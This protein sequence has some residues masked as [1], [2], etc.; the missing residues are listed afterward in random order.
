MWISFAF[1]PSLIAACIS[2][3]L[4]YLVVR[5]NI[6]KPGN[7]SAFVMFMGMMI[8]S[9]GE[10]IERLAG[11]PP[12]NLQYR[13]YGHLSLF[14]GPHDANLAYIGAII[15]TVGM[16]L[17]PAGI[18]HFTLDY[19]FKIKMKLVLRKII[20]YAVYLFSFGAIAIALLNDK[21]HY[22][23]IS[24]VNPYN[25]YGTIIW[26]LQPGRIHD[27]LS[28]W[29]FITGLT[30]MVVLF[31]KYR[32][33]K[34]NII[35]RQ[36]EITLIGFFVMFTIMVVTGFVPMIILNLKN[37]YPLM[38]VSFSIFGL[39]IMYTIAKYRMFLVVATKENA[40]GDEKLPDK[41][42]YILNAD[43]AYGKFAALANSGYSSLGFI[44]EDINKFKEKYNLHSTPLFQISK[45]VGKDKLNPEI[46]EHREMITFIIMSM[47]EQ[48]YKPVI[49]LDF[50][51]A[52]LTDETRENMRKSL[53]EDGVFLIAEKKRTEE[54]SP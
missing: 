44:T 35:K 45:E 25:A 18:I 43:E 27:L 16:Y 2:A 6:K 54:A 37:Y 29:L 52:W 15:L 9:I 20:L 51:A 4:V 46:K 53:I 12:H 21:L 36:I 31:L 41:G 1:W 24:Y 39:F 32:S 40:G 26:G 7:L 48:V 50:S 19:P 14:I 5:A 17:L 47:F 3:F 38:T 13:Y 49:L 22:A 30:L 42:V 28:S 34:I 10:L 11:P 33:S 23:V 8:W